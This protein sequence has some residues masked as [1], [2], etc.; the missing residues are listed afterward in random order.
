MTWPPPDD[1]AKPGLDILNTY[2]RK[3]TQEEMDYDRLE[4]LRSLSGLHEGETLVC[5]G[6]G[7]SMASF[8][9]GLLSDV[10][11]L[12][13]NGIGH[14]FQPDYYLIADPFVYGLHQDVFLT[15]T[16]TR[17]LSSFTRGECDLRL[18]Y[19]REDLVGL[20]R[21]RVYSA[22]STGFLIMSIACVMG[23]SRILLAGY[24][25]YAPGSARYHCYDEPSVEFSRV[26]YEWQ[27]G[28]S[29]KG[30]LRR[31]YHHAAGVAPKLGL[32]ISLIT[33]SQF[34]GDIF[35][36]VDPESVLV[37]G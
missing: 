23:A 2:L 27:S 18:Y 19:R 29:K 12:G 31:A 5:L 21:D 37:H 24:D 33:P 26:Q 8:P 11:T 22:D 9:L 28:N 7:P 35:P 32:E 34:L 10:T 20:T 25:G 14:I 15:C 17:I 4:F 13:C 6:T 1:P 30:L 16:G 3:L 36:F